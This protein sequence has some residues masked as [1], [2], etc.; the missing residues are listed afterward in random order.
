MRPLPIFLALVCTA[1][2][3]SQTTSATTP[4][5]ISSDGITITGGGTQQQARPPVPKAGAPRPPTSTAEP[6]S[7]ATAPAST[8]VRPVTTAVAVVPANAPAASKVA[9]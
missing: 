3:F 6:N 4:S 8:P 7:A 9:Q 1:S 2:G 5:Q